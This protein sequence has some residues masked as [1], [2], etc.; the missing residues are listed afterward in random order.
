[1]KGCKTGALLSLVLILLLAAGCS[2]PSAKDPQAGSVPKKMHA[3]SGLAQKA[4]DAAK[5]VPGVRDAT[6]VAVNRGI[7]VGIKVS[8]FDRLRLKAVKTGVLNKVKTASPGYGVLVTADKKLFSE[9]RGL[10]G[11]IRAGGYEQA[12]ILQKLGKIKKDMGD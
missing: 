5:T 8:G 6:A 1:M 12:A 11:Q 10:E 7:L 9:L 2:T 3:D 4:A